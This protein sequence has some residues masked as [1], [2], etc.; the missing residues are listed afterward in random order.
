MPSSINAATA[1]AG[2][3]ITTADNSGI[4]NLQSS[5]VTVATVQA[6]GFSLPSSSTINAANT[7]G[8]ENRI[9]NGGMTIDQ[10]NAGASVTPIDG[11]F[12]LDRWIS[13]VTAASKF[14]IQQN[15][16]SVTPP[17]GFSNYLGITSLS[18]YSVGAGDIFGIQQR[19][20]GFNTADLGWGTANAK[21]ITLSFWVRSSLTGTF[22]GGLINSA[23]NYSYPF[24]YTISSANTWTQISVTI[25]GPTAG[26]WVGATNGTGVQ[27]NFGIGG[28]TTFSG[29]AGA[30]AA[31]Q[32]YTATGATSVVGTNGAT[33]YITGV[34]FEVGSQA[35][36]FDFRDYGRELLLCQRYCF[37][38]ANGQWGGTID[39]TRGIISVRHAVSMR[40]APSFFFVSGSTCTVDVIGASKNATVQYNGGDVNS[41]SLL[42]GGMTGLTQW[43]P[44]GFTGSNQGLTAEL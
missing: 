2:G 40:T 25:A 18:A 17:V 37:T 4:L 11:Q 24:T 35:T 23:Q 44:Y 13:I 38:N 1:G 41:T 32:K 30:W 15:A 19:I 21:T 22:G 16:G 26:T 42:V 12:T 33:F 5:G 8:F 29:T 34:Q 14:S 39:S 27:V 31:Q 43:Q 3:V 10:R 20:E 9:I 36:S 6:S 7:F 28:G